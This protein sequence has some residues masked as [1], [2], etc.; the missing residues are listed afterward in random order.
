[1]VKPIRQELSVAI[2]Q[3][4]FICAALLAVTFSRWWQLRSQ[5]LTEIQLSL[6]HS[7]WRALKPGGCLVPYL[8][9]CLMAVFLTSSVFEVRDGV[10]KSS[11]NMQV[12]QQAVKLS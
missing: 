5:A 3:C 8:L 12:S 7:G 11:M 2:R 4:L 9:I 6:L 1:M 10:A